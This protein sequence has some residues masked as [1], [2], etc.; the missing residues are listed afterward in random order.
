MSTK[1][2]IVIDKEIVTIAATNLDDPRVRELVAAATSISI[3]LTVDRSNRVGALIGEL[4]FE[5]ALEPT[6]P[7]MGL[8]DPARVI[9]DSV[10]QGALD[11]T[12]YEVPELA[13]YVEWLKSCGVLYLGEACAI[14]YR[15]GTT[16]NG[17]PQ[18]MPLIR[19]I[20]EQVLSI[21]VEFN[22][23]KS[24]GWRPP[25][26]GTF[27]FQALFARPWEEVIKTSAQRT[28]YR[29]FERDQ[30][31]NRATPTTFGDLYRKKADQDELPNGAAHGYWGPKYLTTFQGQIHPKFGYRA[32][33]FVPP[34]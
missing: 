26:W 2:I 8:R 25:Y 7:D 18:K 32:A 10:T 33:M 3:N 24:S 12:I 16:R 6:S 29:Q 13:P 5:G 30:K 17:A 19:Q 23:R 11:K 27:D 9:I 34:E 1:L 15:E 20:L 31:R 22:S 4:K 21:P 14:V 28:C